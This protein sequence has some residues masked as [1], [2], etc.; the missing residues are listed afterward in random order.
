[1]V[2]ITIITTTLFRAGHLLIIIMENGDHDITYLRGEVNHLA[3]DLG[4]MT[5]LLC[6]SGSSSEIGLI[7]VSA[8]RAA[9]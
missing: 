8:C 5:S 2:L 1:M 3:C 4:Q 7:L 9:I 6:A